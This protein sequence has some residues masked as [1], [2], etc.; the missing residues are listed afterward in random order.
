MTYLTTVPFE[1][2]RH[3]VIVLLHYQSLS[4]MRK[5]KY[6]CLGMQATRATIRVELPSVSSPSG[7][8]SLIMIHLD[9]ITYSGNQ[10]FP[11]HCSTLLKLDHCKRPYGGRAGTNS[12]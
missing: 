4:L 8:P 10:A 2:Y 7:P 6:K 12:S 9:S 1:D 11:E 5:T 3:K